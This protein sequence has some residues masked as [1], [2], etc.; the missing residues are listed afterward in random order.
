[1]RPGVN[2]QQQDHTALN[3]NQL[4]TETFGQKLGRKNNNVNVQRGLDEPWEWYDKCQIRE[5]NKGEQPA[6]C[7]SISFFYKFIPHPSITFFI[8]GY[9]LLIR[10]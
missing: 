2:T 3:A 6:F 4:N 10:T 5:R 8:Q 7:L 1:M 9:S